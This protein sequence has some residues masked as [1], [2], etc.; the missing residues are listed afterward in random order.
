MKKLMI[1]IILFTSIFSLTGC[2]NN[3]TNE[4]L[5]NKFIKV[6]AN[7]EGKIVIDTKEITKTA[8][9][10]NYEVDSVTIQFIVV[11]GT[12]NIVRIA[13][14]TCGSCNPSPN[15]YFIQK[16]EYLECQNCG[17]KI[18]INKI[19]DKKGGCTP[20]PITE[21]EEVDNQIILDKVYVETYKEKFENWNGPKN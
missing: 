5:N 21:K 3:K 2:E 16:G 11:R 13:L 6:E 4:K 20:I 1:I 19:D 17:T 10:I 7:S 18:H 14:N 12:D 9:F 15:A 8:T